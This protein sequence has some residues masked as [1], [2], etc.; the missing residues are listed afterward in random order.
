MSLVYPFSGEVCEE[1]LLL[2]DVPLHGMLVTSH[3]QLHLPATIAYRRDDL[4][5]SSEGTS[6]LRELAGVAHVHVVFGRKRENNR[7]GMNGE[8]GE[9]S[10]PFGVSRI[11][12]C[13]IQRDTHVRMNS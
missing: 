2:A 12:N 4:R 9:S 13:T 1:V 6:P 7:T 5:R 8:T 3:G 11:G 10:S